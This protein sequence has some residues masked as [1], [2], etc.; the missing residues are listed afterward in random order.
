V[1]IWEPV[2]GARGNVP[3]E[4]ARAELEH[5][6][7]NLQFSV[8]EYRMANRSFFS[9]LE[10]SREWI[11][12]VFSPSAELCGTG[13]CIVKRNNLPLYIDNN[14]ISRSSVDVWVKILQQGH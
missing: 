1:Y 5:R 3:R 4:L 9:A 13:F 12:G 6:S 10:M 2:P 7:A 14:H 8:S 11:S